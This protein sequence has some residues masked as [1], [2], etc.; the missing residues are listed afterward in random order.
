LKFEG[1]V[2]SSWS[3]FV[4]SKTNSARPAERHKTFV[5]DARGHS[6]YWAGFS[7]GPITSS[8]V[9]WRPHS[10]LEAGSIL[11]HLKSS[12]N[13]SNIYL[14][15]GLLSKKAFLIIT[16]LEDQLYAL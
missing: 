8:V 1:E 11:A 5:F 16:S 9:H 12:L 6:H 14:H 4:P 3:H 2:I 15:A 7:D 13:Q 10:R